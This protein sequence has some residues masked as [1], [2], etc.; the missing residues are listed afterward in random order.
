MHT[1]KGAFLWRGYTPIEKEHR[2]NARLLAKLEYLNPAGS[3]KDRVGN[4]Y[5]RPMKYGL[6]T[7][8]EIAP[9][10]IRSDRRG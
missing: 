10:F 1:P 2:L 6:L 5:R 8:E 7:D 4:A 3:V 9:P